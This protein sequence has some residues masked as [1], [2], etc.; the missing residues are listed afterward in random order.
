[1][2][3]SERMRLSRQRRWRGEV[4]IRLPITEPQIDVL[5]AR[6]YDSTAPMTSRSREQ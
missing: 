1:M 4:P 6:G 5:V 2:T 3:A